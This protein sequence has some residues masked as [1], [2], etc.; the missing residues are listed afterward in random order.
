[1]SPPSTRISRRVVMLVALAT[2]AVVVAACS[3]DVEIL[4]ASASG[5]GTRLEL[6]LSS[7]NRTY[8]VSVEEVDGV[9]V[10]VVDAKTESP[11]RLGGDDC[12][13]VWTFTLA[14]PL[15]DRPLIDTATGEE[16]TV[17][18]DP[19][20]QYLYSEE[21]YRTALTATVACVAEGDPDASA[22][23]AESEEGPY[24][25]VN[26]PDLGD[27]ESGSNVAHDCEAEHLSP[28]RR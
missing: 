8:D 25:V 13:D 24:L 2:L 12:G 1:M 18:Y 14:Q 21:E 26:L 11:V 9:S 16:V 22:F 5:D 17:T 27:G 20:N 19:W 6:S 4:S 3:S 10:H 28:L 15:G 7:C 23:V